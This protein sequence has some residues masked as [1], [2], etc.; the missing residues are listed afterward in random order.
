MTKI[1]FGPTLVGKTTLY[2]LIAKLNKFRV[3]D[4]DLEIEKQVKTSCHDFIL[5]NGEANFRALELKVLSD[6]VAQS[7]D[8]IFLGGGFISNKVNRDFLL[9]LPVSDF[10]FVYLKLSYR[11]FLI[12]QNKKTS[13][14]TRPLLNSSKSFFLKRTLVGKKIKCKIIDTNNLVPKEI[15]EKILNSEHTV[16]KGV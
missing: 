14:N 16:I 2:N 8:Y 7:P 11:E 13:R 4:L 12:R 10:L 1:I 5:T 3:F 6:L 15:L 9:K